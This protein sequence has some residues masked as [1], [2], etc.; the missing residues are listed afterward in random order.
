MSY[1]HNKDIR[2]QAKAIVSPN[3]QLRRSLSITEATP[4]D[5][6]PM[7]MLTFT[8]AAFFSHIHQTL[9][10]PYLLRH[11]HLAALPFSANNKKLKTNRSATLH[12]RD[13]GICKPQLPKARTTVAIGDML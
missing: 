1:D 3:N 10:S 7:V 2:V 6:N 9:G 13:R 8:I 5:N 4:E 11:I 12:P